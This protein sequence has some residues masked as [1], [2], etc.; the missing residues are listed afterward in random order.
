MIAGPILPRTTESLRRLAFEQSERLETGLQVLRREVELDGAGTLDA[1][2][3]D[4][5]GRIGLVF[6]SDFERDGLASEILRV[7]SWWSRNARLL[8]RS[9]PELVEGIGEEPRLLV[10]AFEYTA[11]GLEDLR[12][13]ELPG[14]ELPG[15]EVQRIEA[16]RIEQEI[17]VGV[18]PVNLRSSPSIDSPLAMVPA[19]GVDE[20]GASAFELPGEFATG[21][22]LLLG[23]FTDRLRRLDPDLRVVGDRFLRRYLTSGR[24]LFT[25]RR[26]R[27]GVLVE[28]PDDGAAKSAEF[29]LG[30]SA[31]G[32]RAFDQVL[33]RYCRMTV[34]ESLP[35]DRR[36]SGAFSIGEHLA[37]APLGRIETAEPRSIDGASAT[38]VAEP[39]FVADPPVAVEP[40]LLE[41]EA[42]DRREGEA[43]GFVDLPYAVEDPRADLPGG[44]SGLPTSSFRVEEAELTDDE[45]GAFLS[46]D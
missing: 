25:L 23:E 1:L 38:S 13:L 18:V 28:V 42:T 10:Y 5:S 44:G 33:R 41:Q 37:A 6:L 3:L 14:L 34:P 35:R 21:H 39:P 12:R 27:D 4:A 2:V 11:Q 17:C 26:A 46:D 29:L 40:S 16:A 30:D 32:R 45:L 19:A 7:A 15:L 36:R 9:V 8:L 20:A 31:D 22:E 43:L 24:D